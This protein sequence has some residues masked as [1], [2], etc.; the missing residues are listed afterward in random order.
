MEFL[1]ILYYVIGVLLTIY[2]YIKT[3]KKN[4]KF[5]IKDILKIFYIIFWPFKLSYD[6]MKKN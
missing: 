6:F 2:L 4:H 3:Y 5:V 1:S